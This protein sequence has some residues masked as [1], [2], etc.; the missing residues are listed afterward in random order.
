MDSS[1]DP[2]S[3]PSDV[4]HIDTITPPLAENTLLATITGTNISSKIIRNSQIDNVQDD[5][6]HY[7]LSVWG[8]NTEEEIAAYGLTGSA[9]NSDPFP[10]PITE[11]HH[12]LAGKISTL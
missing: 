6:L 7:P 1:T 9:K 3:L 11:Y 12:P 5:I 8:Y 2:N 4:T 10:T